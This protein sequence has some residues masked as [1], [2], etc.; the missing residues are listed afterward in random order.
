MSDSQRVGRR[1]GERSPSSERPAWHSR[2]GEQIPPLQLFS[3]G[4]CWHGNFGAPAKDSTGLSWELSSNALSQKMIFALEGQFVFSQTK[5]VPQ[6]KKNKNKKK[7]LEDLRSAHNIVT[8]RG[9][10]ESGGVL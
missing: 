5:K 2:L 6:N 7:N 3:Q 1:G 8:V 4:S 10:E 9:D